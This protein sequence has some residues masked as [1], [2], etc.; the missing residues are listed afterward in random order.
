MCAVLEV[1]DFREADGWRAPLRR[2]AGEDEFAAME[3]IL[4]AFAASE[5]RRRLAEA[6]VCL[7]EAEY[8]LNLTRAGVVEEPTPTVTGRID[9]LWQAADGRWRLLFFTLAPPAERERVW[10]ERL[11]EMVLAA[12]AVHQQEG[13]WP[14]AVALHFL[15]D[16]S[17]VERSPGRL[18]HR[19]ILAAAAADLGKLSEPRP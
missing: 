9:C 6:R 8:F 15:G 4:K 2:C 13:K 19:R 1:W 16:G 12:A 3:T 17:I 10:E 11:P 7:H 18:A 5:T 14:A